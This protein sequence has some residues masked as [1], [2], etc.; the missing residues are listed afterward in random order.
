MKGMLDAHKLLMDLGLQQV[1]VTFNIIMNSL[2]R[3][4]RIRD[5]ERYWAIMRKV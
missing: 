4:G 1:S 3:V 5:V 2:N